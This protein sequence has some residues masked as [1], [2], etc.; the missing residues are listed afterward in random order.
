MSH[1]P[2]CS[3]DIKVEYTRTLSGIE[4]LYGIFVETGHN[5]SVVFSDAFN[6]DH[7]DKDY[8]VDAAFDQLCKLIN[9]QCML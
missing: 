3:E 1:L 8:W 7:V 4:N 5:E 9:V 2:S 6:W